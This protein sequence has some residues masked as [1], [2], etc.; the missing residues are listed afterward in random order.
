MAYNPAEYWERRYATGHDSGAGS[1]GAA[2]EAKA[3]YL[4]DLID[5]RKIESLVDW[6]CGDGTVLELLTGDVDYYGVDLSPTVIDRHRDTY[7]TVA[8]R[9]FWVAGDVP[10]GFAADLAVSAD[11]LHH[12]IDDTDFLD[13]LD[14]VFASARRAVAIFSTD[15]DGG[16]TAHHV[17]WRNFTATVAERFIGWELTATQQ[18]R[19][20][21]TIDPS[22][23]AWYLFTLS[24]PAE[25]EH[26]DDAELEHQDDA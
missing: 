26:Q 9:T 14:T 13:Y 15:H 18:G 10:D 6:G 25:L 21:K 11:V 8:N 23:P 12:F 5:T 2:A 17:R 24:A 19:R 22:V 1:R 7:A 4:N 20:T 16:R 3:A